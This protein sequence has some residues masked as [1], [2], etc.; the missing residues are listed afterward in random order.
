M[1][2]G[3]L[4]ILRAHELRASIL[5]RDAVACC[6][7]IV[8]EDFNLD[9]SHVDFCIRWAETPGRRHLDCLEIGPLLKRMSKTQRSKLAHN[10]YAR[11]YEAFAIANE[12]TRT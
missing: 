2:L 5:A 9:D 6:W 3:P 4:E 7:H 10:G 1:S 12:R 8:L 11:I